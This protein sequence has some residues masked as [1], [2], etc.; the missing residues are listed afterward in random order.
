MF[1]QVIIFR[2]IISVDMS[3]LSMVMPKLG[4]AIRQ[5]KMDM[6]FL[7]GDMAQLNTDMVRQFG[8]VI[9]LLHFK[10]NKLIKDM[11]KLCA[12]MTVLD[13]YVLQPRLDMPQLGAYMSQLGEDMLQFGEDMSQLSMTMSQ[14]GADMPQLGIGTSELDMA[15]S[16]C[17]MGMSQVAVDI[18]QL[19]IAM[20]EL[21][22]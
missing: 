22:G 17:G 3:Q 7:A 19:A 18:S 10:M 21:W 11:A 20:K 5:I 16:H 9:L 13:I 12:V 14:V 15:M 4:L 6:L 1:A 8:P 2:I